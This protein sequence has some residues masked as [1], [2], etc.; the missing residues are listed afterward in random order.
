MSDKHATAAIATIP[1]GEI[2]QELHP[3]VQAAIDGHAGP[4]VLREMLAIQRDWEAGEARK[5]FSRAL[6]ALKKDLPTV[7]R[8]DKVVAFGSTRYTH[9]SLASAV[10]AVTGPLTMH[11][12]S[13]AW[14][15]ATDK[16]QVSVTCRLTHSGGHHEE[17]TI[18]APVDKA[19]SKSDAQGVA[20]T[21]T[22]LQRYSLLSLLGIATADMKDPAPAG[23]AVDADRNLRAVSAIL[24]AGR[25]VDDAQAFIGRAVDE[26]TGADLAKL[27]GWLKIT[28]RE[29]GED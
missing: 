20:S 16:G 12:F 19:G 28:A 9:T 22:L 5:A 11:G 2:Q 27:K 23:D 4:E 8:R 6:V 24:K 13:V 10:E 29:P 15:P 26:W 25:S 17:A 18:A 3:M 7:I 21:I 1:R 14:T